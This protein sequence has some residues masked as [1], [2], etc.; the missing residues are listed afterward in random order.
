[1][2][3]NYRIICAKKTLE[4]PAKTADKVIEWLQNE[5]IIENKKTDCVLSTK[6]LGYRPSDN[7]LNVLMYDENITRLVVC[8]VEVHAEREVFNAMAFT[9]L[10][11]MNCPQ[12]GK[13]RFEGITE[14]DF[15][16]DNLTDEQLE[17][18]HSVF[19][20]F[21]SWTN[22]EEA[23]LSCQFCGKNSAIAD[24]L[25]GDGICLSNFGLTFWN[26]PDFKPEFVSKLKELIGED[27]AEI[28]G[29]I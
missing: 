22:N 15:Y 28:I 9:A 19:S 21:D 6:K 25:I 18:Y 13:N 27:I 8:G 17:L 24:Y 11:K 29:H 16:M 1:M 20:V 5:K 7:H 23:F 26:W 14:Q 2:S 10:I 3:D 4:Y 12:C